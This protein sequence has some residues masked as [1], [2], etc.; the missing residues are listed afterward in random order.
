MG[1]SSSSGSEWY[2]DEGELVEEIRRASITLDSTP[3]LSGYADLVEVQRG[4]QG[5]VYSAR[6]L[7]TRRTVAVKVLHPTALGSA[8]ARRRF[9]REVELAATL[10]H[11]GVVR[12]YD[13]GSTVDGRLFLS[14]EW[15]EGDTLDV[16]ATKN[17]RD[18]RFIVELIA[19]V[20]DGLNH[21]H[22]RGVIHRDLK[23]SNIRLAADGTPTILDF[24]LAR[25]QAT[26]LTE[27]TTAGSFLGS[28][29]WS[30]PE[31][32]A[33]LH[34]QVDVRSDVYSVGVM[35]FQLVTGE[36]PYD[37]RTDLR[38]ALNTIATA[39]P[40]PLRRLRPEV[41]EDLEVVCAKALAKNP[42]ERYQT[43]SE[44]AEDLR[45]F[46]AGEPIRA[47]RESMWNATRRQVVRYRA[48]V[49]AS[50]VVLL[51]VAAALVAVVIFAR[52]ATRALDRA[53]VAS[54]Q[55]TQQRDRA[56]AASAQAENTLKFLTTMLEG[57]DP[58]G[59][60]EGRDV[61]VATLLDHAA[62]HVD[63]DFADDP[64]SLSAMH[65]VMGRTYSALGL[66][67]TALAE[68]QRSAE[69]ARATPALGPEH[70]KTLEAEANVADAL[71]NQTRLTEGEAVLRELIPRMERL[72]GPADI[73]VVMARSDLGVSLRMQNKLDEAIE[74]YRIALSHLDPAAPSNET[75]LRLHNNLASALHSQ[76]KYD[77]AEAQYNAV[78]A[79][80][81]KLSGP[82]HAE[83][84][85]VLSN[86]ATLHM[87]K[88]EFEAAGQSLRAAYES[89]V[90]LRGPD[91]PMTLMVEHNLAYAIENMNH[92]DDALP[93]WRDV[94]ERRERTLGEDSSYT[95]VSL[96]NLGSLLTRMGNY[97][98]GEQM[99]REVLVRR[100]RKF[101]EQNMDTVIAMGNLANV[102]I[103][104]KRPELAEPYLRRAVGL[105]ADPG[106]VPEKHW[107]HAAYSSLLGRCLTMQ[108]KLDEAEPLL[109]QAVDVLRIK[110]GP[111][112]RQTVTA[113]TN[114]AT[115][116]TLR[117]DQK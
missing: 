107:L 106:V 117:A 49:W 102:F 1:S 35:L 46:L 99:A 50:S 115:W 13:S 70:R 20:C 104:S 82:D 8:S 94:V 10:R 80:R 92:Y 38:T 61:R 48:A 113:E 57:A 25:T 114:L 9:E 98:E 63:H 74:Q 58:E 110:A 34:D 100:T 52:Q 11:P 53:Q 84:I 91:H 77:E 43:A 3:A 56:Q 7:A 30:S 68:F 79:E 22:Q 12:V 83:T 90:R 87:D 45:L 26:G 72:L 89:S 116:E 6:H 66:Y 19:R 108:G 109:R 39:E 15:V 40:A 36:F 54:L 97:E 95:L 41:A 96:S 71:L 27:I 67:D 69:I 103:N 62:A 60:S 112:H 51:I 24:G 65:G 81:T 23:P 55:A 33:G 44:L 17:S 111:A 73:G 75:A 101:G 37:V 28:L 85:V 88:G 16:V 64:V 105:S 5:V 32:A 21:A 18:A 78:L 42:A 47:K 31:Q 4:G 93:L 29:P 76:A 59:T 14:M 2:L 86:L